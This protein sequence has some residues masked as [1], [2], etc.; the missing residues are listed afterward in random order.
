M[1]NDKHSVPL[2]SGYLTFM[3]TDI[4]G[5]TRMKGQM[6]GEF[7]SEREAA[8][9]RRIKDPHDAIVRGLVAKRGGLIVKGTGDGF[10]IVFSDVEKAVL[11]AVEIQEKLSDQPIPTPDGRPLQ[12]RIGLNYGHAEPK[13]GDYSASAADKAARVESSA[14]PGMV[15]L[16]HETHGL[17]HGKVRSLSTSSAG[18]HEMRGV[19]SEELFVALR[20]GQMAPRLDRGSPRQPKPDRIP[21]HGDVVLI[22]DD[23]EERFEWFKDLLAEVYRIDAVQATSFEEARKLARELADGV[24]FRVV[25]LADTLPLSL[26]FQKADPRINFSRLEE[27]EQF[28]SADF[29]CIVTKG[30]RPD[31]EGIA[32]PVHLVHLPSFPPVHADR[33]RIIKELGGLRIRPVQPSPIAKVSDE[34]HAIAK[35]TEWDLHNRTLRR[36]IRSLS[37]WHNLKDGYENLLRLILECFDWKSVLKIEVKPLGQGKSGAR[38]FHLIVTGALNSKQYVLKLREAPAWRLESEVWGYNQAKGSTGVQD[39]TQHVPVLREPVSPLDR[40]H[41]EKKY[42]ANSAQWHAIHYDFLGGLG[43]GKF[44]DLETAL[45]ATAQTLI[46]MTK[47][48][49]FA[50]TSAE[51]SA[52]LSHRLTIFSATLDGLVAIWYGRK[53][54]VNRKVKVIWNTDDAEEA[55]V[56]QLPPYQLT[57][58]VKA[59]VE[60]FLDSREAAIGAR[61]FPNWDT[62]RNNILRLVGDDDDPFVL[63]WRLQSSIPFILSPVHGDLNANNVLLWLEY[64]YPFVIDLPSYQKEGHCLQDFAR[65]EVEIKLALLDRQEESP[66]DPL[67]AYDYSVTQVPL[68]IEMEDHLRESQS[69]NEVKLTEPQ[70]SRIKWRR[71]GYE[72]NVDLCYRLVLLLR[73]KACAIQQKSL[74]DVPS[75]APFIDEY[76]P[77]LLYHSVRA[78]GYPSLSIFKRLLA[79]YSA[80]SILEQF[81]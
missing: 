25:F 72:S 56:I 62:L 61:L 21:P 42:I 7:S 26:T 10:F 19:G 44:I 76:L 73:H 63:F 77:A 57:K 4:V 2:P 30:G 67:A 81:K 43:L 28:Y 46:E 14:E 34:I 65:L 47:G 27:V 40:L 33:E 51:P 5:S 53:E 11:C 45:T 58:R 41:P 64:G 49:R 23:S 16:S 1:T 13:D 12:I 15:Y 55:E 9:R 3:F 68:W 74:D 52:V 71:D 59:G 31:L 20:A 32:G 24:T 69:L 54:H 37:G 22:G 66:I 36:Q 18:T 8:F 6:P 80:G 38:V 48:T 60:D 75:P 50:L 29:V 70:A 79:I 39:Y 35:I 78:I 17:I